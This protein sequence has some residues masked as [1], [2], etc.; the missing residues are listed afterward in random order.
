MFILAH[1]PILCVSW[2]IGLRVFLKWFAGSSTKPLALTATWAQLDVEIHSGLGG[3]F[4][5]HKASPEWMNEEKKSIHLRSWVG[6]LKPGATSSDLVSSASK[7]LGCV[8]MWHREELIFG[9]WHGVASSA[10]DCRSWLEMAELGE[11]CKDVSDRNN[12][13]PHFSKSALTPARWDLCIYHINFFALRGNHTNYHEPIFC[14]DLET[15]D[16]EG[17]GTP[18]QYSCLENPMGRAAW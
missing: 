15:R 5:K 11:G 8:L 3:H 18:L 10:P 16:G 17:N 2:Y 4:G 7:R 14:L 9:I 12:W 13:L 6:H 1:C